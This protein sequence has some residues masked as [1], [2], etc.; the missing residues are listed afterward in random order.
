MYY[1]EATKKYE[2]QN[3]SEAILN[4]TK[5]INV[6]PDYFEAYNDRGSAYNFIRKSNKAIADYKKALQINPNYSI[7]QKNK[8]LVE[9]YK[10]DKFNYTMNLVSTGLNVA[11][12]TLNMV[13]NINNT[14]TKA[15][16]STPNLKTKAPTNSPRQDKVICSYCFG[17]TW[18]PIP[19]DVATFG[20]DKST[21]KQCN[22]CGQYTI[23]THK[24]CVRCHGTGFETK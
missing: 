18:D 10:I 19:Y 16:A 24:K 8:E 17:S 7:A 22:I 9:Q 6:Y 20:L 3:Y 23:H 12:N 4:Y 1:I 14:N 21:K 5:A 15:P 13:N 11:S 2:A